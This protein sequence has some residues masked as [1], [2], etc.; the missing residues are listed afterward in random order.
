[1]IR[2]LKIWQKLA[3]LAFAFSIPI[4]VLLYLLVAEKNIAIN[5]AEKEKMGTVYHRPLRKLLEAVPQH[6]RAAAGSEGASD[7]ASRAD[8]AIRELEGLDQQLR[9]ELKTDEKFNALKDKWLELKSKEAS[10]GPD[11]RRQLHADVVAGIRGLI[12]HVGDT[13][14]LIL[15]PD[16][17]SYY[18]MDAELIKLPESQDLIAQTLQYGKEITARKALTPEEKTQLIVWLGLLRSNLDAVK[19]GMKLA[20]D[21]NASGSLKPLEGQVQNYAATTAAF[22]DLTDQRIANAPTIDLT[23][24]EYEA[25]GVKALS[26]SFGLWDEGTQSLDGLLQARIDGFNSRKFNTFIGVAGIGLVTLLL[27][28]FIVRSITRPLAEVV[29]VAN[30][31]AKGDLS[32]E[33][34]ATSTDETGQLMKSTGDVIAYLKETASVADQIAA[35]NLSVRVEPKSADDRFGTSFKNMLDSTLSLVQSRDERD[36]LQKG[37]MTLL[38][39]ISDVA[40]GDLTVEAEVR[41]DAT[42]AI[43]DSFNFMIVQLREIINNV[44]ETTQQ[45]STSATEIQTTTETLASGSEEQSEQI[46]ETSSAIEE[47]AVSIQQVSENAVLSAT[48]ADQA[49]TNAKQGATAVQNNI[50]A[51]QRI[52]E[53]VQE[54]AKRIKRLGE[55]SQEIGEIVQLIDDLADRTSM[56]ALNASI[57]AAMAGEAGRGFAVVAEEVERL[58]DRSTNATKQISSLIKSIQSET[59]EAVAAME[60]TTREV[61]EGSGLAN[62]AGQALTEIEGVSDRLAELIQSISQASKQQARGSEALAKSMSVISGVTQQVASGSREAAVSVKGMVSLAETLRSSVVAFKLPETNGNGHH[63]N[64]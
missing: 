14:N 36:E 43:A 19:A 21:N 13:S 57:Q 52:R 34:S 3:L 4:A 8:A 46:T 44:K 56:L 23:P 51:M 31:L 47:M 5:F 55:R 41:A 10:A 16:L 54:T 37:F 7:S 49:R 42:G 24:E 11:V 45:V 17:D 63:R 64:N 30:R 39:E 26:A 9:S 12:A 27:A 60:D 25:A 62:E 38:G 20:I 18:V 33:I 50:N 53:Q 61:V 29:S 22:L 28:W 15:D 1:M 6:A 59:N 35:G 40:N 32:V 58:A 48:V 2:N